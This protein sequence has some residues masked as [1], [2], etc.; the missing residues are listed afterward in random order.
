MAK[1]ITFLGIETSC[2]ETAAAVIRENDKGTADILSNIV[3]SQIEEHK[4][5]GGVVPELAARAHLENIEYIIDTA[6]KESKISLKDLDGVA[7]PDEYT[8]FTLNKS[9]SL[10]TANYTGS[11]SDDANKG[12]DPPGKVSIYVKGEDIGGNPINGGSPGFDN[13]LVTYVSMDAKSPGIR[14]F[15]IEDSDRN[16]LRNPGEGAPF[17][18]GPWNMTMYAGKQYHL[19]VEATDENGWKDID[20]FQI[21]LGNDMVLKYYPRNETAWTDSNDIEIIEAGNGSDGPQVLRMDG[22]RLVDPFEENF[23]LDLPIRMKWDIMGISDGT[24]N[25]QL[26]IKDQS[27]DPTVM[28]ETGGRHKQRWVYSDGIQLDFRNGITPTFTDMN[29]P[30]TQDLNLGFVFPGDTIQMEGQYA[31]VDGINNGVYVL[32]EGEL[33]VEITRQEAMMNT[34]RG[35]FAYPAG[36]AD[37]SKTDGPTLHTINGGAFVINITAPTITNEYTYT[38]RLVNLPDG[39]VD[40]SSVICD[41]SIS[42]GCGSFKIKVDAIQP[43]VEDDE[44]EASSGTNGEVFGS[45]MPSSALHCVDV[46]SVIEENAAL[47]SGEVNLFWSFYINA[48]TNKTWPVYDQK[49]GLEPQ[50]TPLNLKIEGGDYTV[51]ADCVDLWPDPVD[52][53]QQQLTGVSVILWIE[54]RDSAGW[55]IKA[56]GPFVGLD[57]VEGVSGI[58]SNNPIHNSEYYLVYEEASFQVMDVRL[59]PKSPEVGDTPELEIT[60]KNDGTKDGNITI[61]IQ[62]VKEGGFPTTELVF[63]TDTI[64]MGTT[65]IIIVDE[66]EVFGTPTSGM[67]FIIRDSDSNMPLWNGSEYAKTFNVAKASDDDGFLSGLGMLI[68]IGLSAL[69]LILLLAVVI[70]SRRSSSDGTYEYEYQYEDEVNNSMANLPRS[71]PPS[72]GPP[73]ASVDPTMAAAMAEFPQWDQA[74]IQGYFDQGWDIESLRDWVN[75]NQ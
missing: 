73:P 30:Y 72:A 8:M 19:I 16:R 31:Y 18:Q 69:I 34:D 29:E 66:L 54:G 75:N 14:N 33:T 44:W 63:T 26:R 17:Y 37:G 22:G 10:P 74:T 60:L 65:E 67:Y 12:Q 13:D 7:D 57:G 4:R 20:Y 28:S 23:Y 9:G 11:I 61:E 48:E 45:T 38:F 24:I 53:S 55:D 27:G 70:L 35:Y 41:G 50:N 42:N 59:T 2:D 5:F 32:P 52:P 21:D 15:Y 40:S 25:P 71:G 43:K 49:F 51:S 58:Y 47:I 56:G 62:S 39:A 6:L 3:S 1:K 36:G 46:K 68:V 64:E